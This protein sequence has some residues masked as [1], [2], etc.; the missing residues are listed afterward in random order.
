MKERI[1]DIKSI[2]DQID[3]AIATGNKIKITKLIDDMMHACKNIK[4]QLEE[5]KKVSNDIKVENINMIP[6]IYKPI[7]KKNYYE[8]TYLEE[9]AEMRTSEL[10][11]A[12]V[13]DIH[14]KFWKTHEVLR[15]NIFGSLPSELISKD[16][17]NKLKYFGW[18]EVH[19]DVLEVQKRGCKMQ[20]LME[21]C[22]LQ[23]N[24]FL[25]VNEKSSG[26]ELILHYDI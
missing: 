21:Y 25:I 12:K 2:S 8:G 4:T 23:Y 22:E 20:E 19:V 15:G 10:K 9:F 14:N 11:D 13:L 24:H 1:Q 5:K 26:T 17:L 7:L 18:D 6:F 16:A 3:R